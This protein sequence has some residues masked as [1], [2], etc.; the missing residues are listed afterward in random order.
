M[1]PIFSRETLTLSKSSLRGILYFFL[2]I[3][4]VLLVAEIVARSPLG[5]LLPAPSVNAD[6]FLFDAKI[7]QLEKQ[8][9]RDG[10]LDC[11]FLGSSVANSDVDPFVV[12][13]IYHEKTGETIHCYNL[14][15]PALTLENAT[16]IAEAAIARFHPKVI[17]YAILPRDVND[18]IANVNY[19]EKIDWVTFHRG[20]P[21]LKGWLVN[22]S[23][24]WR[25]FLTWRYWLTIP[26]RAKMQEE[27]RWL[28]SKGFQPAMNVREPYIENLTMTPERLCEAWDD[29][30]Q[31]AAV[32]RFLALQHKGVR[33]VFIEGP[34][35]H[36]PDA[37][38][39]ETW[40]AYETEYIPTLLQILDAH[41]VPF[42]RTDSL[43]VQIP[44]EHWYDWLHLNQHGAATF[45]Q[46]IGVI[47]AE[48]RTVFK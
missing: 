5:D 27:T 22:N 39:S 41:Q 17:I 21:T 33:I 44:K 14:G 34:A 19:L 36:E 37:S 47:M 11:L 2:T 4:I 46:W 45:S 7:Y 28:T 25:Y 16:P 10:T 29:P 24:G 9:Q 12:E 35:Y 32:E 15:L 40:L 48:N 3:P 13:K 18:V 26:N 42:W 43:A 23:H 38:D 8:I 30:R 20:A 1:P 31:A 6:S